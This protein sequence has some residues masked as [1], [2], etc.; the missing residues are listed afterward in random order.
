MESGFF[1]LATFAATFAASAA[2]GFT[3]K[4]TSAL[5]GSFGKIVKPVQPL[6]VTAAGIGLPLLANAIG[7]G[8]VDPNAFMAAPTAT[9]VAVSLREVLKRLG[10]NK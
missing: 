4:Y 2:L 3:K 8:Q 10:G 6:L 5:D 9:I 1:N 7:I